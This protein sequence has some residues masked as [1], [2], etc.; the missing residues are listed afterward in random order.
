ML[1]E[2]THTAAHELELVVTLIE[3]M[4]LVWRYHILDRSSSSPERRDEPYVG[5]HVNRALIPRESGLVRVAPLPWAPAP[6]G[7]YGLNRGR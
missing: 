7:A 4:A 1:F 5:H 6:V 3:R 2:K